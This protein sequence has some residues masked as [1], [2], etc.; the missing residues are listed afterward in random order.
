MN[1]VV[2]LDRHSDLANEASGEM[3]ASQLEA[4][5]APAK[6]PR[7][8]A[9]LM[10]RL[11]DV[12]CLPE[13]RVTVFERAVIADL[14]VE[15][16]REAEPLE[17]ERVARRISSLNEIPNCL[18]RLFSRDDVTI[19]RWLLTEAKGLSDADLFA[20]I[21]D[22]R[23]EHRLMIAQ[24][25]HVS[26]IIS[27]VL[28]ERQEPVVMRA[29]LANRGAKLSQPTV[30]TLVAASR[31][32]PELIQMLLKRPELRPS[33]AYVMFWW[34]PSEARVSLLTRF[35]VTRELMQDAAGD[36]FAIAASEGWS[37]ALSRKALQFIERRQR[38]REAIKK[39]PYD[40]LDHAIAAG[41]M[42]MTRT[43]AE[44]ISYLAGIKPSTGTK[45][46]LDRGGEGVA[47]MCKATGLPKKSLR[48]LWRGLRRPEQLADGSPHPDLERVLM[49]Y[50]MLAPDRA[51]TVL[52]YWNWALSSAL[53]SVIQ[54][55][56]RTGESI[57]IDEFSVP[58]KAAL[59]AFA[60]DY[61]DGQI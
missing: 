5:R 56:I 7:S 55:A 8:R 29:L 50:D 31:Q 54:Q 53:T 43:I 21:R 10:K 20:C 9:L 23:P 35:A 41:E 6:P 48:Q 4:L 2:N 44:E 3:T 24:R 27:E 40:S 1:A 46:M 59:L 16:L 60:T 61:R 49:I 33:S 52:R 28:V 14:L 12:V 17:R 38:N 19:A 18:V 25:E 37:D 30:E 26:E 13:T 36:V 42:R 58:Q 51:Q 39:S 45:I 22:G 47:V 34:S 57:D 11:A 15:M 32:I